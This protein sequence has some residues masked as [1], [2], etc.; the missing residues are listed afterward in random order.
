MWEALI[1]VIVVAATC[2]IFHNRFKSIVCEE[3]RYF[4]ELLRYIHL[5][6][7]RA[8]LVRNLRELAWYPFCGHT[9]LVGKGQYPCAFA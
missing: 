6:S 2:F 5:N 7:L 4:L 3:E 1:D 9:P 8:R